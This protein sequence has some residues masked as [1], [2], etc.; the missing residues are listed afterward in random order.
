MNPFMRWMEGGRRFQCN[1]CEQVTECPGYYFSHV[2]GDGRRI[3][4]DQRPELSRGSVEILATKDYMV[5]YP[6][7][8]F[9]FERFRPRGLLL[10]FLLSAPLSPLIL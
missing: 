1:F 6:S 3:D 10:L 4:T 5:H 8:P 2:G 9:R 7:P